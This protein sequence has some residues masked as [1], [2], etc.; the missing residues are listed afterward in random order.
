[1]KNKLKLL[2]IAPALLLSGCGYGLKEIYP[3]TVYIS[4]DYYENFYR[5]WSK[6]VN[7]HSS[8]SKVD[9]VEQEVYQL[10]KENDHVFTS[11]CDDNFVYNQPDSDKYSYTSDIYEP[12]D[13]N[14]RS[15]FFFFFHR[16]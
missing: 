4:V 9:N 11:F 15:Q 16:L 1:M 8:D 13:G 12:Q 14:I 7:Y 6:D 2:F 5:E 10:N 3:G